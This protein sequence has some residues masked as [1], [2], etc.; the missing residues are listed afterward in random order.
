[1]RISI[2]DENEDILFVCEKLEDV[3]KYLIKVLETNKYDRTTN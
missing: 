3:I 2:F 1:M